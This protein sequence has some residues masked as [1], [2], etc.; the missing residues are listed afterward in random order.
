MPVDYSKGRIYRI[1]SPSHIEEGQYIGSTCRPLS[2]RMGE[3]K[4]NYRQ[5]LAGTR[6]ELRLYKI[7]QHEDARIELIE[8]FP[9]ENREQLCKREG[10]ILRTA[11]NCVNTNTAGRSRD[12]WRKDNHEK[13]LCQMRHYN[14][15]HREEIR[16]YERERSKRRTE[17]RRLLKA[18]EEN[19]RTTDEDTISIESAETTS[20]ETTSPSY[21]PQSPPPLPQ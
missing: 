20:T 3:H 8:E 12:E 7:L 1:Y 10:E 6:R 9:C 14:R 21:D 18:T 19:T 11:M 15:T 16:A 2:S 4:W 13:L 17:Q 5:Y